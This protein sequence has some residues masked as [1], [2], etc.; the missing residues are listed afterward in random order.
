M[1]IRPDLPIILWSG[2]SE[3]LSEQKAKSIGIRKYL[4]KPVSRNELAETVRRVID[5]KQ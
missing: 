3:S 1:K 5:N 4:L 2:Y